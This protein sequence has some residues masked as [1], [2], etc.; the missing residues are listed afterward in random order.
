MHRIYSAEHLA[1][2]TY[3]AL[4]QTKQADTLH[5]TNDPLTGP[6]GNLPFCPPYY[7]PCFRSHIYVHKKLIS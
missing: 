2:A 7:H 5:Q 1:G 3:T 6:S 4:P